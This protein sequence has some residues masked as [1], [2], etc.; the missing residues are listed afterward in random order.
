MYRK[1]IMGMKYVLNFFVQHLFEIFFTLIYMDLVKFRL[2]TETRADLQVKF[3]LFSSS[4]I[5][6]LSV[7]TNFSETV[8]YQISWKPIIKH[9]CQVV[10]CSKMVGHTY[11]LKLLPGHFVHV[12]MPTTLYVSFILVTLLYTNVLL[13]RSLSSCIFEVVEL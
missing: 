4:F 11:M 13:N 9:F 5:Q 12:F 10:T 7:L 1:W 8:Q 3:L 2:H 6:N